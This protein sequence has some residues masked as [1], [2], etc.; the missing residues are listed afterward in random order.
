MG[1]LGF[2][3]MI[4]IIIAAREYSQAKIT[5]AHIECDAWDKLEDDDEDDY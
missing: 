2:W 5:C 3:L 1:W 4:G